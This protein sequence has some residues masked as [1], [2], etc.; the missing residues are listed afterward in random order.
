MGYWEMMAKN[1]ICLSD[2]VSVEIR[3]NKRYHYIS[4]TRTDDSFISAEKAIRIM[5]VSHQILI[6]Q[7]MGPCHG[8]G[9][10][11]AIMP[12]HL[13]AIYFNMSKEVTCEFIEMISKTNCNWAVENYLWQWILN[14]KNVKI[15]T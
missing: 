4:R 7:D 9:D 3:E 15:I 6:G 12:R 8:G 11:A 14:H 13:A 5:S 10:W 1:S 2:I